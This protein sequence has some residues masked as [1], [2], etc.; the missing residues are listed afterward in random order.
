MSI[1]AMVSTEDSAS[2][3]ERNS[4]APRMTFS[5]SATESETARTRTSTCDG[6]SEVVTASVVVR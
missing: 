1:L 3:A 5:E 4:I 6:V 2:V